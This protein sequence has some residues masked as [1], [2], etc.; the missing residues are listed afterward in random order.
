MLG[1]LVVLALHR[2]EAG[3]SSFFA[4]VTNRR[5]NAAVVMARNASLRMCF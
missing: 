5:R 3:G 4:E 2:G 1:D